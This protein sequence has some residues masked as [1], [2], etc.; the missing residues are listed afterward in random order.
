MKSK[1]VKFTGISALLLLPGFFSS[2]VHEFPE[3]GESTDFQLTVRH[4][5]GWDEYHM[6]GNRSET[7]WQARYIFRIYPKGT[8]AIPIFE[9]TRLSDDLTL[10]DFTTRMKLPKGEWDIYVWQDFVEGEEKTFY[11]A[12]DFSAITY[13][14]PYVGNTDR[15]DAFEGRLSVNVSSS[16]KADYQESREIMLS[17]PVAKYVFIAT[18]FEKFYHGIL[19]RGEAS[20]TEK[21][22]PAWSQMDEGE[23]NE[24]I[25]N[26]KIVGLYPL[27]MPSRYDLFSRKIKD[28][29]RSVK[30]TG[31]IRPLDDKKAEIAFDY[32]L[33]DN[34]DSGVQV[35]IGLQKPDGTVS[36]LSDVITIPIKRSRVTYISGDFLTSNIG[37][38]LNIDFSFSGD[39]NIKI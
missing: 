12:E 30:Y 39:F 2:C 31:D 11:A 5:L 26:Y 34:Q 1:K 38:G 28:S 4:D 15:R 14:S 20:Q 23:R 8:T 13:S 6:T 21:E 33:L 22:Y 25:Q 24:I 18:D 10:S 36:A 35:Q 3:A 19:T 7:G 29:S 27:F 32:V 16:I 9:I 17:R 37:S